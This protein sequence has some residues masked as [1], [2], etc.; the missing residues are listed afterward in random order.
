M[1]TDKRDRASEERTQ[2]EKQTEE[3]GNA[4][5]EHDTNGQKAESEDAGN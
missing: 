1:G 2:A 3:P 5:N 4:N